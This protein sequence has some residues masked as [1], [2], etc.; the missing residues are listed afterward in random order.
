ML[1]RTDTPGQLA[2]A[3]SF[4]YSNVNLILLS[5]PYSFFLALFAY[6]NSL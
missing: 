6:Q 2:K 1:R 5:V 3:V 4:V